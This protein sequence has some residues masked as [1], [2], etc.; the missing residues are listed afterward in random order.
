MA[1]EQL[2]VVPPLIPPQ[3]HDHGP[4]PVSEEAVPAEHNPVVGVLVNAAPLAVPHT[5]LTGPAATSAWQPAVV[6]PLTPA[7]VQLQ[8]PEP[9]TDEADPA[10]HKPDVGLTDRLRPLEKPQAPLTMSRAEQ[11]AVVPP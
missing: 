8:G 10:L 11:L 5:P 4:E 9:E 7:H 2:A 6:P 3:V 1:A